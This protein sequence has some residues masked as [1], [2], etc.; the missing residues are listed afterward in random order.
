MPAKLAHSEQ[1]NALQMDGHT[2]RL[3]AQHQ[4]D[5]LS[6]IINPIHRLCNTILHWDNR[7]GNKGGILFWTKKGGFRQ[8]NMLIAILGMWKSAARQVIIE[9]KSSLNPTKLLTI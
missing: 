8:N 6:W 9:N 1:F 7:Y 5:Q 3:S 2:N 4:L